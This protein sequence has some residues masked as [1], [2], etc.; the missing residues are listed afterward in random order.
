MDAT[1]TKDGT[2]S[3]SKEG[4]AD[5]SQE[6]D[7][8]GGKGG[9]SSKQ[10]SGKVSCCTM[11]V[12]VG[13]YLIIC[14]Q[15]KVVNDKEEEKTSVVDESTSV[16]TSGKK[17]KGKEDTG[18]G[19]QASKVSAL[20]LLPLDSTRTNKFEEASSL[21]HKTVYVIL[22]RSLANLIQRAHTR[23]A[24]LRRRVASCVVPRPTLL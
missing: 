11:N 15:H 12:T 10:E 18:S 3:E 24:R 9:V 1:A 17:S 22:T 4:S 16:K 6:N 19:A 7:K 23:R 8:A 2:K 21:M 14:F 13:G 5:V 20:L